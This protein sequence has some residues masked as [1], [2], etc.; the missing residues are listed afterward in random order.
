[1]GNIY[2]NGFYTYSLI[3][4]KKT[5]LF[6]TLLSGMILSVTTLIAQPTVPA[7]TPPARPAAKV[8]SI[9]SD[10]Y[11]NI[12]GTD[13]SP[14]WG[15]STLV[16]TVTIGSDNVLRYANLN[17]QG[18]QLRNS[19]NA[20][21]MKK[22]HVDVWTSNATL[23]QITPISPGPRERLVSLTPLR[24]NQWNSFD[25][26]LTQF[27]GVNFAEIFQF[28]IEGNG[29][30]YI[31]NLYFYDDSETVDTEP[32]TAFSARIGSVGSDEVVLLM[33]ATD[34]SGAVNFE[35]SYGTN[36]VTAGGVSGI[37]RAFTIG[38][39]QGSTSYQFSIVARDATGNVAANSPIVL[40][41]TTLPPVQGAPAPVHAAPNVISIFSDSYQSAAV[42][43]NF[44]P[45][46][47]QST[48]AT[49]VDLSGINRT[50]KYSNL[51]YQGIEL[52][53]DVN[54]AN[55]THLHVDVYTENESALQI[56][57]ISNSPVREHL[58]ALTPLTPFVW[59]RFNIPLSSFTGVERSRIFQFKVV[60]S[61][62]KTVYIDNLFFHNNIT[63]SV[64]NALSHAVNVYP[65]M[66]IDKITISSEELITKVEVSSLTGQMLFSSTPR[67][68]FSS[69]DLSNLSQGNYLMSISFNNGEKTVRKF[70]KL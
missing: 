14:W 41:A 21:T 52:G 68:N 49:I 50:L 64:N 17:Y 65:T 48:V 34:N 70:S 43:A 60:G 5:T 3:K 12:S 13:F 27:T 4:M 37:Q 11:T 2:H 53:L 40:T 55:M 29:T 45:G 36:S 6:H 69:I 9:F 66:V 19:V 16:S 56:S 59:N 10:A 24:L 54:A 44:F 57:P 62:G 67:S 32:P 18:T 31:D 25:I 61:G 47:G 28:K 30:V 22:L 8:I 42:S 1:M 26:D 35:V 58:V 15:Q 38:N 20:L 51:N 46:W 63:A 39:L 7:P 23:L 33:T